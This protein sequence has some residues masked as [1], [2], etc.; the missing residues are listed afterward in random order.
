VAPQ[1]RPLCGVGIAGRASLRHRPLPY[2]DP[3]AIPKTAQPT[4]RDGLVRIE[5]CEPRELVER[6]HAH[7]HEVE[8]GLAVARDFRPAFQGVFC[9]GRGLFRDRLG[10]VLRG[11]LP[12]IRV[13][14]GEK[15]LS[16]IGQEGVRIP[17]IHVRRDVAEVRQRPKIEGRSRSDI[18]VVRGRRWGCLRGRFVQRIGR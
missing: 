10:G 12:A 7:P 8:D 14:Y 17:T 16:S 11:V 6:E 13:L 3:T 9:I 4:P 5:V 1:E 15:R 2:I 18:E